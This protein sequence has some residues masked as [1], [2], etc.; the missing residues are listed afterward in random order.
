MERLARFTHIG[1]PTLLIEFGGLR[2]LTDPTFNAPGD[3]A[4]GP[5]T[6]KKLRG[7]AIDAGAIGTIDAI[8]LS[9]DQHADNLDPAG[10]RFLE[11]ARIAYTTRAGAQRLGHRAVGLIPWETVR[12]S[13]TIKLTATPARHGPAG[14]EPISGDVIG[15]A[16]GTAEPGDA[17]YLTGDTVFYDGVAE[18]ARR[19]APGL[20]VIFAG[21]AR[22]RGPFNLTMSTNDALDTAE[23]FAGARILAIH[24]EGWAHFTQTFEDLEQAFSALGRSD[25][26][27]RLERGKTLQ[28]TLST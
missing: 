21:A 16:L 5:V 22:A 2:L 23:A 8:L 25:Q 27:V 11:G 9:H 1:G 7:P 12:L 4:S 3:Y 13:D 17:L 19:F 14:I 26:L 6:L 20:V 28:L 15:F 10:R 24:T 18:V